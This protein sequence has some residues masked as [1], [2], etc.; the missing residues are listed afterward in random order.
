MISSLLESPPGEDPAEGS[1][2]DLSNQLDPPP[3]S[4]R[5]ISPGKWNEKVLKTMVG[6]LAACYPLMARQASTLLQLVFTIA[7]V[8]AFVPVSL[9]SFSGVQSSVSRQ[10]QAREKC[11]GTHNENG[12]CVGLGPP[13]VGQ[14]GPC[15]AVIQWV[16]GF[17]AL[18]TCPS[19]L[20]WWLC[21]SGEGQEA[22]VLSRGQL[23]EQ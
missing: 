9:R 12:N 3:R 11:C 10:R 6:D 22:V 21:H 14:T 17:S 20:S 15:C 2:E 1:P 16:T 4:L 23:R 7:D 19:G 8:D 13:R 18:H 5:F